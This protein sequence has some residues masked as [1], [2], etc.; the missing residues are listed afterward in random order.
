MDRVFDLVIEGYLL[1]LVIFTPLACGSI[2]PWGI[3]LMG[4]MVLFIALVQARD[5]DLIRAVARGIPEGAR[6][7]WSEG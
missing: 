5:R 6:W 7:H 1:F 4:W 2:Y 3:A